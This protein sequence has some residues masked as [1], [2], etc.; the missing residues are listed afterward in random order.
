LE[1]GDPPGGEPISASCDATDRACPPRA[2]IVALAN[3]KGGVGKTTTAVN[4]AASLAASERRTLLIDLDPQGN[5]TSGFGLTDAEPQIYDALLGEVGL[6]AVARP[7]ELEFLHVAPAGPD[8]VGA[9]IEL[10]SME[11]RERRLARALEGVAEHYEFVLIDCPPSLG[12][13]TLNALTAAD[14][15]LIPL[16]CEY[17]ALE[18][19]ARLTQT[20]ER[21]RAGLNPRLALEGIVFTMV[22][23]RAN[24]G[25]QVMDEVRSHFGARVYETTVPRN[26]RLSE[27]PSHGKPIL[28]YDI[29]SRGAASYLALASEF[30]KRRGGGEGAHE[31]GAPPAAS[32]ELRDVHPS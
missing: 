19:L 18:G 20:L 22:D 6:D 3:Q 31:R 16:Q 7:T 5:A 11:G 21:V 2:S 28:L 26:V 1:R 10:V 23:A 29:R 15:V 24:L 13:L 8:L 12:L 27:A 32:E 14:A 25:R 17:Y 30:L 4:L 9:E